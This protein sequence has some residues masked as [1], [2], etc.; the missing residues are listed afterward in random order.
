MKSHQQIKEYFFELSNIFE[1]VFDKPENKKLPFQKEGH[2]WLNYFYNSPLYRHI[3]LEYYKTDKIC[4]LHANTFPVPHVDIP[5][6]GFDMI[7]LGDKI[8][9]LFFDYTPII[10][11][12]AKLE[13]SLDQLAVKY[14]SEKRKLP[15]WADF[16]SNKFYC[17]SPIPEEQPLII[18][19]IKQSISN[20]FK[21]YDEELEKYYLKI[22]KQ[23]TYCQ[24]QKK[25][26]KT[27]KALGVEIGEKNALNFL[28]DYLFPEIK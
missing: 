5:I 24:G 4:V 19:D 18:Q 11:T 7:A 1:T 25:N 16:F 15:E 27:T 13:Y 3:H 6:L 12:F 21:M 20:Y 14:K 23:N 9:G 17:V 28:N 22:K 8:T 10:T 26:D 2:E